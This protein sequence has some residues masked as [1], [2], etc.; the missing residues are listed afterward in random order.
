[1]A[2]AMGSGREG[3]GSQYSALPCLRLLLLVPWPANG[4]P[5]LLHPLTTGR[6]DVEHGAPLGHPPFAVTLHDGLVAEQTALHGAKRFPRGREGMHGGERRPTSQSR[7]SEAALSRD[8]GI[9][10]R[11]VSPSEIVGDIGTP[12][13]GIV[14]SADTMNG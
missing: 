6:V 9:E 8:P 5:T 14:V 13:C 3:H 1:M 11:A 2:S 7:P 10:R 12:C 4:V